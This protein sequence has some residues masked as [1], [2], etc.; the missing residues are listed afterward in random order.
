M[1]TISNFLLLLRC[2]MAFVKDT[3]LFCHLIG[4]LKRFFFLNF[5]CLQKLQNK[6]LDIFCLDSIKIG[7]MKEYYALILNPSP[8]PNTHLYILNFQYHTNG[9]IVKLNRLDYQ[10][11]FFLLIKIRKM[12][13]LKKTNNYHK[14]LDLLPK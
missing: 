5:I 10:I 2:L 9:K 1:Y 3:L 14:V 4:R 13:L 8:C 11:Y 7:S 6:F 12:P